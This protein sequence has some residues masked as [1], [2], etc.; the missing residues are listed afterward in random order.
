MR[1]ACE[2]FLQCGSK[3]PASDGRQGQFLHASSIASTLA[4][5]SALEPRYVHSIPIPSSLLRSKD[6][7]PSVRETSHFNISICEHQS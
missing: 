6:M 5:C 1:C 4:D 2:P 3:R 7:C